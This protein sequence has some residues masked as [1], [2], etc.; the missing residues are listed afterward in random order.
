MKKT[1][2]FAIFVLLVLASCTPRS[3]SCDIVLTD[4]HVAVEGAY[5]VTEEEQDLA[6]ELEMNVRLAGYDLE[7]STNE[8]L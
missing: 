6:R 3:S 7:F 4:N 1:A 2:V 8:I 5:I